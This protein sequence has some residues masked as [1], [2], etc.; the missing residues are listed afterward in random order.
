MTP[1][2]SSPSTPSTPRPT[3]TPSRARS[4]LAWR[5]GLP[6][7]VAVGLAIIPTP[8]G[9]APHAWHYFAVFVGVIFALITEPLPPSAVGFIGIALVGVLGLVFSPAQRA[10]ATFSLPAETIKWAVSGFANSTVWLIFGAFVFAMGYEQTGLGRRIALGLVKKLGGRTLGLGYAIMLADL[11]LAPFTPSNTARS[12]GTIF[13]II[14]NIPELYGSRPHDPSARR[15]GAYLMWVALATTCIT[16]SLFITGLAP[17]V[18]ALGLVHKA[19][20]VDVTWLQ[21]FTGFAPVGAVLLL[22]LPWLTYVIY[23]PEIRTSSEVPRWAEQELARLGPFT[24]RELLM[25]VFVVLALTL[26]I[27]GGNVIDAATVTL[28]GIS[29]MLLTGVVTWDDILAN[30]PA[31]NVL[32]FFATVVVLADGLNKVG[33]TAWFGRGAATLLAG[34]SPLFV[35]IALVAL[36][37]WLHYLFAGLTGHAA[38]L[39]P[40]M[41][42]AGAAVPGMPVRPFALLLLYCV[43]IMGVL[44]PYACGPS[45]VYYASGFIARKDFWRLG[46][47]FG[48]IFILALLLIGIPTLPA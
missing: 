12:A 7:A 38:A 34:H 30:K 39:L 9:L 41:A 15:I 40:V 44:T 32:V 25:V 43:G 24:R 21:W 45:P 28:V 13:P 8:A 27:F 46:F 23:P 42:A 26:W 48:A 31:W 10:A 16:G 4:P 35:M 33:F 17:N 36:F 47:I 14:R 2:T 19:T 37:Y 29:L 20:G 5:A 1:I 6:I 11:A 22:T 3:T 18:L